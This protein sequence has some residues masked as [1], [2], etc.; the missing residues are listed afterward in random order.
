MLTDVRSEHRG[1]T[2]HAAS[3]FSD[4]WNPGSPT[5]NRGCYCARRAG[6]QSLNEGK[7]SSLRSTV[8]A[9]A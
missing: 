2:R 4:Y 5:P 6:S 8:P 1:L 3:V 7:N 9:A